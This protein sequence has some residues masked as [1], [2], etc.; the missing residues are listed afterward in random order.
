MREA[1]AEAKRLT[2][3]ARVNCDRAFIGLT[4]LNAAAFMQGRITA[5]AAAVAALGENTNADS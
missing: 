5:L 3:D 1:L 2:E 4:P